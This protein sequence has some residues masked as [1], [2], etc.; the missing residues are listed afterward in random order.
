MVDNIQTAHLS[1]QEI[2]LQHS[3]FLSKKAQKTRN[4]W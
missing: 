1:S 4:A 2:Y 3:F